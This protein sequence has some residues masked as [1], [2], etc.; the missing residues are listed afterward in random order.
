MWRGA[1]FTYSSL[2]LRVGTWCVGGIESKPDTLDVLLYNEVMSDIDE[3]SQSNEE[4]WRGMKKMMNFKGRPLDVLLLQST[5]GKVIT[6]WT[7][8]RQNCNYL[9]GVQQWMIIIERNIDHNAFDQNPKLN[10]T[11]SVLQ[12]LIITLTS[13]DFKSNWTLLG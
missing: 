10:S 2:D 13:N 3:W 1:L 5:K 6:W 4:G 7:K 11:F 8:Y 12:W 9:L